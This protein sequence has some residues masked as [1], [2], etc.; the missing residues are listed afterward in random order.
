V[1]DKT[2]RI[3]HQLG[4]EHR[5]SD[6]GADSGGYA[7]L[8]F[9]DKLVGR[10]HDIN[11]AKNMLIDFQWQRMQVRMLRQALAKHEERG[12]AYGMRAKEHDLHFEGLKIQLEK[13]DRLM[14]WVNTRCTPEQIAEAKS[15][16]EEKE[17]V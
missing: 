14:L 6:Y 16:L 7:V 5:H 8:R 4:I 3:E 9:D 11:T 17:T 12:D 2:I 13:L 15:V 1:G 10:I